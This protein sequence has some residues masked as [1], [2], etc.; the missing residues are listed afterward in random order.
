MSVQTTEK[1][2]VER[3]SDEAE[4]ALEAMNRAVRRA[5]TEHKIRGESIAVNLGDGPIIMKAADIPLSWTDLE[6]DPG[7]PP[8]RRMRSQP[9]PASPTVTNGRAGEP[10]NARSRRSSRPAATAPDPTSPTVR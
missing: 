2:T 8:V 9:P 7:P 6:E 10:S 4:A 5:I 1:L 3:M